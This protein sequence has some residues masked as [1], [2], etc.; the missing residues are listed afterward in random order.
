[1]PKQKIL[2]SAPSSDT[3]HVVV[4]SASPVATNQQQHLLQ[5]N[6]N[7]KTPV[8]MNTSEVSHKPQVSSVP[9]DTTMAPAAVTNTTTKK[10]AT[11][12]LLN[13]NRNNK[14]SLST[15]INQLLTITQQKNDTLKTSSST[16]VNAVGS[17]SISSE[18]K[19]EEDKSILHHHNLAQ[20]QQVSPKVNNNV[21][22]HSDFPK[23]TQRLL[24]SRGIQPV[25]TTSVGNGK[26]TPIRSKQQVMQP[27]NNNKILPRHSE[28]NTSATTKNHVSQVTTDEG[29]TQQ[30]KKEKPAQVKAN[31]NDN[32]H[33]VSAAAKVDDDFDED[34][35]STWDENLLK[36]KAYLRSHNTLESMSSKMDKTLYSWVWTQ[37][38]RYRNTVEGTASQLSQERM[39]QL[40][41]VKEFVEYCKTSRQEICE[42]MNNDKWMK[43]L[44]DLKAYLQR[45]NKTN[46]E[47]DTMEINK[48][49]M[50]KTLHRWVTKHRARYL[51]TIEGSKSQETLSQWRM[52]K[53]SEVKLFVKCCN[54]PE[55]LKKRGIAKLAMDSSQLQ[56]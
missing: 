4:N 40:N 23:S 48:D 46:N 41:Q 38:H 43:N 47:K 14:V 8:V 29:V 13:N 18:K 52:D 2:S 6:N 24:Q 37:R 16:V 3:K 45:E 7:R 5:Q 21:A 27:N 53:L 49:K 33:S 30:K 44:E 11:S 35:I 42:K 28:N 10:V 25:T 34:K 19:K 12:V 36:L 22:E 15:A 39:N 32:I 56:N 1:M 17:T 20:T 51:N 55:Y 50:G 31:N 54:D 26:V 9:R